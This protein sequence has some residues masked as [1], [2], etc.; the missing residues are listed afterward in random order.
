[1]GSAPS[2]RALTSAPATGRPLLSVTVPVT[3]WNRST[4]SR[5]V[6]PETTTSCSRISSITPVPDSQV[7]DITTTFTNNGLEVARFNPTDGWMA[8]REDLR[9]WG[10][11]K[12]LDGNL[13]ASKAIEKG[14]ITEEQAKVMSGKEKTNLIFL[15]GFSTAEKITDVSGRGVGMDVVKTNLDKLGGLIDIDSEPGRGSTP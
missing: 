8:A 11:G 13:L 9:T 1:M 2:A 6:S 3:S 4:K 10:T 12:G 5:V 7:L 14:L 15:P